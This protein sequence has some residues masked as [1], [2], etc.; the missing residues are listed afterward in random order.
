MNVMTLV[1]SASVQHRPSGEQPEQQA[2]SIFLE[3]TLVLVRRNFSYTLE[4]MGVIDKGREFSL[5]GDGAPLGMAVT[6]ADRQ[7]SGNDPR[8]ISPRKVM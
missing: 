3:N 5:P 6:L 7:H 4:G 8:H 1:S 2:K